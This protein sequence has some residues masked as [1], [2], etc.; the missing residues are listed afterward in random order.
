MAGQ[1]GGDCVDSVLLMVLPLLPPLL[2]L[3]LLLGLRRPRWSRLLISLL[4]KH[5]FMK[6]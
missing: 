2:L 4:M 3:L 1:R 6:K 5:V